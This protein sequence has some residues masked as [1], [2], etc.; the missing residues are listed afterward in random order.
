MEKKKKK[1]KM[2][3]LMEKKKTNPK[4]ISRSEKTFTQLGKILISYYPTI[5]KL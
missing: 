5:L 3:K 2:L 4:R 1:K